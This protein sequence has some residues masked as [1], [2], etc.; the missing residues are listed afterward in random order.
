MVIIA[1]LYF[2]YSKFVRKF[3]MGKCVRNSSVDKTACINSGCSVQNSTIGRYTYM[4]YDCEVLSTDIGGFCSLASGIHTGLAEHPLRWVSTSPVFM[5]VKNSS[6]KKRFASLTFKSK[7]RTVIGDDVW[8]GTNAIIKAGVHIGTGAVIASG[9]VVTKDVEP[10]AIVGGCPA[11]VIKFRFDKNMI[12]KLL[13]SKWWNLDD[14]FLHSFGGVAD[15]PEEFIKAVERA[16]KYD[17]FI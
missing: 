17:S 15:N 10:Y 12:D 11:K 14:K 7:P 5:K 8:I 1:K 13:Q 6:V 9:A 4:G 2:F 16:R 3:L